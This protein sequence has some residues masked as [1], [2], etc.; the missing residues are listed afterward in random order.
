MGSQRRGAE[1]LPLRNRG[2]HSRGQLIV[3]HTGPAARQASR[4]QHA[5]LLTT[6]INLSAN[7]CRLPQ[8]GRLRAQLR[9]R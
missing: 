2:S 5:P 7:D 6:V 9:P 1:S 3:C 4:R 8:F